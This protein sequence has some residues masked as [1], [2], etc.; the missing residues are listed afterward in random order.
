M[1]NWN[2]LTESKYNAIKLLLKGGASQQEAAEFMQVSINT[3]YWVNKSE[4]FEDYQQLQAERVLSRKKTAKP[5]VNDDKQKKPVL[6]PTTVKIEA[7]HY[8]MVELQKTN[9]LLTAISAK[10]AYI[11]DELTK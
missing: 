3:A 11:V 9:E 8:M 10:L 2:K 7:T 1:A 4:S 5:I 6:N